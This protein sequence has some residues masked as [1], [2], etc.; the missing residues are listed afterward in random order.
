LDNIQRL[1]KR[2]AVANEVELEEAR[3]RVLERLASVQ[4][5]GRP[6][7]NDTAAIQPGADPI[8]T[9]GE[10]RGPDEIAGVEDGG[11][12]QMMKTNDQPTG[13]V[14]QTPALRWRLGETPLDPS[15]TTDAS[16]DP[17][18]DPDE[19]LT[20]LTMFVG[21]RRPTTRLDPGSSGQP[22]PQPG[23]FSLDLEVASPDLGLPDAGV[24]GDEERE[25]TAPDMQVGD[26]LV[27][28]SV[29]ATGAVATADDSDG[30]SDIADANADGDPGARAEV[31][32]PTPVVVEAPAYCPYCATTLEP[33]PRTTRQCS[34]CRQ[35]IMVRHVDGRTV[36]L[37]EAA[38][39][40]FEAERKRI[41][42]ER[43]WAAQR[44]GWLDLARKSGA[45]EER[46]ARAAAEPP[47]EGRVAAARSMYLA[48]VD[49]CFE[50]A[51]RDDRWEEAARI[52]Y[53]EALV[54]FDFAKAEPP[55][56]SDLGPTAAAPSD[57]RPT[58]ARRSR[59]TKR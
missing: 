41:E 48:T 47:T 10:T 59:K 53:G 2:S 19:D 57:D 21:G 15:G 58:R 34:Q 43:R 37:A 24:L 35:R 39:P 31:P 56:V 51:V 22:S 45:S 7:A 5:P 44:D 25:A 27:E 49:H 55:D 18:A 40:V 23:L 29:A 52:R 46:I 1:V 42:K 20:P 36:Y 26:S 4:E 6:G 17:S 54:L 50:I 38:L 16:D 14:P 9:G 32:A 12:G 33:P 13:S 30:L 28:E 8:D 11:K 3:N